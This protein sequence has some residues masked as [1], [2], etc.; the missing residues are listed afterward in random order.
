MLDSYDELVATGALQLDPA[1][2]AAAQ[3]L[4][5][6]ADELRASVAPSPPAGGFLDRLRRSR[7]V[8][9]PAPR[10]LYLWGG[11]GRGK[12]MLMDMFFAHAPVAAKRRVHFHEFMLEVQ[13]RLTR[14]RAAGDRADP[15]AVVAAELAG[16]ARLICFD[17]FHVV[18]IADAMILGR[19]FT[20]L[21]ERDVVMVATSNWPPARLYED[22]L[23]RDRFLPF[24]A[25]LEAHVDVVALDGP[26]DY[27]L[28]RLRGLEV[29]LTPAGPAARERLATVF[30]ALGDDA[31]GG[32]ET[33]TVGARRLIV[34]RAARGTAWFQFAE[35]CAQA[36]GA[37]DYLALA[38]R[39]HTLLLEDVPILTPDRRNEAR[40]FMTL[41]DAAY[42]RR[43][44][45]VI[46]A[47]APPERLYPLG[48]GAFEFQR[49]A[50]RLIEMQSRDWL[51]R[52]RT[53]RPGDFAKDFTPYALTSDLV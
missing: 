24:I 23:N 51:E 32:A 18:N 12:S 14:L 28:E 42:E 4:Q 21:F 27:R 35:L 17:E 45:L 31:V 3:R 6:L 11:V 40:R 7:A 10:G 2:R 43:M 50:S 37:A 15:L 38:E 20:G 25:L 36:L 22:G 13:R 16:E 48:D 47:A 41:V 8:A 34:P 1:Q 46:S 44:M 30:A 19:L 52:C 26:T 49:T 39:Y 5:R 9:S 33:L 53:R 29:Y